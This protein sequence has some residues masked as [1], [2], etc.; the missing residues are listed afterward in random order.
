[1]KIYTK[2]GDKGTTSLYT[3]ERVDKDSPRVEAY[4]TIDELDSALGLA[5]AFCRNKEVGSAVYDVQKQLARVM[6]AV[7]SSGDTNSLVTAEDVRGIELVIDKFDSRLAP[8]THFLIPGDNPASA[9]LD[10]ART[11]ARRAERQLWHLGRQEPV[12]E[13]VLMLLNRLS[14]LCFMLSRAENELQE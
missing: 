3:G 2:S 7:A 1:M 11:V 4:G 14:D 8:L 13:Q 5:R 10:L 6:A 9:A 12:N